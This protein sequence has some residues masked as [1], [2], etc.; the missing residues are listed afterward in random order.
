MN[1]NLDDIDLT[2]FQAMQNNQMLPP[3]MATADLHT[4]LNRQLTVTPI[5]IETL[6]P[7]TNANKKRGRKPD[8]EEIKADK[9]KAKALLKETEKQ[10]KKAKK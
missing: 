5:Q 3:P 10:A 4:M 2:A 7:P 6:T 8:S 9:A 1:D